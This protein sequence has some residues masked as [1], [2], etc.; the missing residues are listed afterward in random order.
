M[1]RRSFIATLATGIAVAAAGGVGA[2]AAGRSGFD[3]VESLLGTLPSPETS[4]TMTSS[5]APTL[6]YPNGRPV[7]TKIP[8][9]TGIYGRFAV[10]RLRK[11]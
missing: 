2:Y 5:P 3:P 9:A 8:K 10:P 6:L 11:I 4:P 7:P 1:D